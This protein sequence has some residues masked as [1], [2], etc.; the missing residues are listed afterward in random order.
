MIETE[1]LILRP[2]TEADVE[3][4]YR[5]NRDPAV[6]RY[7][8]DPGVGSLDEARGGLLTRPIADYQ[9]YG[10]GR[11]ACVLKADGAVIGFAGLKYLYDLDEVDLG[12]RLLPAYWGRG[13]A[14][15]AA[16]AALA[17][18]FGR[19]GLT[20][21]IGLVDPANAASAR[22]LEKCGLTYDGLVPYRGQTVARYVITAG[23]VGGGRAT[24]LAPAG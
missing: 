21:V 19:L 18:G 2:Y 10:F 22:V 9:R 24:E 17:D 3:A 7:T 6:L 1:C 11:W 16:R 4:F 8:G 20:R 5:L 23:D 12:Y 13:L 15:E 14:T